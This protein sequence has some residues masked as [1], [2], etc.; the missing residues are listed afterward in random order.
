M[1]LAPI[2]VVNCGVRIDIKLK[3]DI[4]TSSLKLSEMSG[5]PV[6]EFSIIIR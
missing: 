3:F 4:G 1:K 5:K 2:G 6:R